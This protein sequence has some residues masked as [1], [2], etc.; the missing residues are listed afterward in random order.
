LEKKPSSVNLER[1]S[2]AADG[3]PNSELRNFN[4]IDIVGDLE[5]DDKGNLI[6]EFGN[7]HDM[8]KEVYYDL[9]G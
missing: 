6:V 1:A 3:C 7:D 9:K 4:E 2:T 8:A 5:R